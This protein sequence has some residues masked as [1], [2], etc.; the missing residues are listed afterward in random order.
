MGGLLTPCLGFESAPE[1]MEG[2]EEAEGPKPLSSRNGG[3]RITIPNSS[4]ALLIVN[5]RVHNITT[6][7]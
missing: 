6:L 7:T 3:L 2:P 5:P 4:S 1:E